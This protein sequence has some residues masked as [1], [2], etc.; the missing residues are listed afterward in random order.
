MECFFNRNT[1]HTKR[2][3]DATCQ[4]KGSWE[5]AFGGE[6]NKAVLSKI[7]QGLARPNAI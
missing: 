2:N 5:E 3:K 1:A 6:S 7:P 4:L